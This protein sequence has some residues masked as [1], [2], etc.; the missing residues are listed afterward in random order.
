MEEYEF[1]NAYVLRNIAE[2]YFAVNMIDK[3]LYENKRMY[4][5]N[6][7]GFYLL[8]IA[9]K[10]SRFTE[11]TLVDEI[12]KI[13]DTEVDKKMVYDDISAFCKDVSAKGIFRVYEK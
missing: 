2:I 5:I 6:R 7:M 10:L 8:G 4:S 11:I 3:G 12:L 9:Q 13:L 1:N